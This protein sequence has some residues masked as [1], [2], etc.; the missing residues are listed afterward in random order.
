MKKYLLMT[1]LFSLVFISCEKQ[2][3]PTGE[4]EETSVDG[5]A[6]DKGMRNFRAEDLYKVKRVGSP[7]VSPDG[8][9]V[10]FQMSDPDIEKNKMFTDLYLMKS[11]GSEMQQLT[12]DP[13]SDNSPVWSPDGKKIAFISTRGDKPQIYVMDVPAGTPKQIT[14][15][16]NGASNVLWSPDGEY[17]SYTSEV[18]IGKNI[19][20]E[21]PE[22]E[23]AKVRKYTE[24]PARHWD[25][26]ED[27]KYSHIFIMPA[28]GG[29]STDIMSGEP[30]DAPLN[31]FGGRSQIAWS[32]DGKQI[33][34]TCKKYRGLKFV[35]NTDSD[36]YVYDLETEE[37]KNITDGMNGFDKHPVYSPDNS[38]IAF[39]SQERPGFESDRI[40]LMVYKKDSGK[41]IE[42]TKNLDQWVREFV[43]APTS[44]KF[45][46]TATDS[47]R[48]SLFRSGLEGNWSRLATGNYNYGGGL[49]ITPDGETVIV[50]RQSMMEPVDFYAVS[51]EDGSIDRLTN[52][53]KEL[54]DKI[55]K[56]KVEERWITSTDGRKVHTWIVY[57]PGFDSTKTYP[58]VS[59][60]QGGPQSMIGQRFHYRWN[61]FL[62]ASQDYIMMLPNRRGL[63]GFGQDWC[64]AISG[65]W[66]GQPMSDI[67]ACTDEMKKEPYVDEDRLAAVGA[68][69][70]GYAAFWLAGHHEGRFKAFISHCGVFNL[71][72]EYGSTE[73]LWFPDW[74]NGGAYWEDDNWQY[75]KENSP[76]FYVDK[77]DT[78]MMI[79]TGEYDFRVPYT[80]SLEAFTA[81][82]AQNIP[83]K[84]L[85]FPEESHFIAH[86][87]E[88]IIWSNE[89]FS[90]LDKWTS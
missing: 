52:L 81:A 58:M 76:H 84:L 11:D 18:K 41:M 14:E 43:W 36:I 24:L 17:I 77:W 70:G 68:S 49:D 9:W 12:D 33:A 45:Y 47:G 78:P 80:Q 87:Q 67:L 64:D 7:A 59:Y 90:W 79:T 65:D 75:Y 71:V 23:K 46:F 56:A 54:M 34:Y 22:Y 89:F 27:E 16:E 4:L 13:A 61:Y 51:T 60:L 3:E 37:T 50:G 39:T 2:E 32:Q 6:E 55:N 86:P 38:M 72:S 82:K 40:R 1:I 69:A 35:K 74:E 19:N 15:A 31:P 48:I 5:L 85:V 8:E 26:W 57:P 83:A 66:G 63:P 29:E 10:V 88:F 30:Y 53:N 42:V 44:D 62:M 25:E 73:E 20:D 21:Y 28:E